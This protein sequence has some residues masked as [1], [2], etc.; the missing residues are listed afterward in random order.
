M[1][2]E[3]CNREATTHRFRE[4]GMLIATNIVVNF[5]VFIFCGRTNFRV[6]VDSTLP[7]DQDISR[8]TRFAAPNTRERSEVSEWGGITKA[9]GPYGQSR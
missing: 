5:P 6:V 4:N 8:E 3:F 2:Q 9:G 7:N 1:R